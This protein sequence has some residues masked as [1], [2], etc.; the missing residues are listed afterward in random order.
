MLHQSMICEQ[1]VKPVQFFTDIIFCIFSGIVIEN[2]NHHMHSKKVY[3]KHIGCS[4]LKV[5][6]TYFRC[7]NVQ[8]I[9]NRD[10]SI[11]KCFLTLYLY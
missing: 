7:A 2:M 6:N 11:S 5:L 8:I 9:H 3:C 10:T 1:N 4:F